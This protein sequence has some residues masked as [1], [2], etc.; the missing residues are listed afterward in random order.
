MVHLSELA[1]NM[2]GLCSG[3]R[4]A[5]VRLKSFGDYL[6]HNR[7]LFSTDAVVESEL[8]VVHSAQF[9]VHDALGQQG[10]P[11][12]YCRGWAWQQLLLSRRLAL[13]RGNDEKAPQGDCDVIMLLEHSHVYT[14]GRGADETHMTCFAQ[15]SEEQ[16][17]LSRTYRGPK[18]ARLSIDKRAL[19][20]ALLLADDVEALERMANMACPVLAPNGAPIYRVDRGGEVT[21]HGPGQ[22]VVYP[23]ID[24]TRPPYRQDLHWYLRQVEEIVIET[25][26]HYGIAGVRDEINTGVWVNQ[27][28]IAAVGVSA[29]RWITTHGLALNVCPDL[30]YFDTS[31][32]LPC[33]IEG[34]GVTSM[35]SIMTER[36]HQ[37][38][39]PSVGDV[40]KV[41]LASMESVFGVTMQSTVAVP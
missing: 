19:E 37:G 12:E 33:G 31:V 39:W 40:S 27:H 25:L 6:C 23:L 21:Y 26:A 29:S 32:I 11:I 35:Q 22:L 36:G 1:I 17:R 20:D 5:I 10:I 34:R 7:L 13:R 15:D 16:Q 8:P 4:S 14:L 3:S 28:K 41:V 18:A 9:Q 30:S 2:R 24:L 38:S